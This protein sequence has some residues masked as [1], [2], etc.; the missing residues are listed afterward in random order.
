VAACFDALG[1]GF[2]AEIYADYK[3]NRKEHEEDLKRQFPYVRRLI[4]AMSIHC[5]EVPGYEADDVLATMAKRLGDEGH[6]VVII[7]GDKDLM[8]CVNDRVILYDPIRDVR[9]G[10]AEV[11]ER[12][13]VP[14]QAVVDVQGLMGDSIDNIPGVPGVGPKTASVLIRHFGNVEE[15]LARLDEIDSLELRGAGRVREKVAAHADAVRVSKRLATARVDA[16][17]EFDLDAL[18]FR[19]LHTQEL[20]ELAEELEM[21]RLAARIRTLA[22]EAAGEGAGAGVQ[23]AARKEP[24]GPVQSAFAFTRTADPAAAPAPAVALDADWRTFRS[25]DVAF[26]LRE[27]EGRAA[28]ALAQDE[29]RALATGPE[30]AVAVHE[31][32]GRGVSLSGNDLKALCRKFAVDP[33]P[34]SLDLGVAS[35]LYDPSIGEH[36]YSAVVERFLGESAAPATGDPGALGAS[37][38]QVERLVPI[39]REGLLERAQTALYDDIELP[40]IG[41]LARIEARGILLDAELLGEISAEFG[42]RMEGLVRR[43]YEAAGT[44]FNVLSPIQ[45]RDVLFTRL[46]LSTKGVKL[47]KTGPSTDSDTLESLAAHHP[48]PGLVLEYR[49]LAKLKSTYVDALPRLVDEHGR[50]HTQLNQ[51]VAAT[52]RLSSSEPNLQNI[53][54]RSDDGARIRRAF[55]AAPGH[56]LISADYNQIELRVLAHLSQDAALLESFRARKD[57]HAAT[58]SEVFDVRPE[59]VTPAM[60]RATKVINFGIIYGMGPVRLSRELAITRQQA[61]EYIDRY[62]ARYPGVRRFYERMLEHA[63]RHGY[64]ET[65]LGRR[66]YLPDIASDHRGLRQLAERIATN[67]PIQGSAADVIKLAMVRLASALRSRKLRAAMVLQIHDEL[68]LECPEDELKPALTVVREAMEEAVQLAVPIV[69]DVGTGRSWGEAH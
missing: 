26:V 62:F 7:T 3:A 19:T 40:L 61:A 16:P 33:V 32:V 15:M 59:D 21:G 11:V 47:T 28:L 49:A 30:V 56:V 24:A 4:H 23:P 68:L 1:P 14:P 10:R 12:F 52:G 31:L 50:I 37:L 55:I 60:R 46:G 48:L 67:T 44:E 42:A 57:I 63:R 66:R 27:S 41:V 34:G 38:A 18:R 29:R 58:A 64:V 65:L 5:V 39:L 2:R 69:V 51:T 9:V 17:V 43:I 13:G 45:L 22:T 54:I 36:G 53:P 8:Q 25:G 20:L 6:D 35:Y